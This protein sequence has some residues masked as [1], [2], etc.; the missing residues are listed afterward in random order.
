MVIIMPSV[1]KGLKARRA[2][3]RAKKKIYEEEYRK[4]KA[5]N[6]ALARSRARNQIRKAAQKKAE[7]FNVTGL[8]RKQGRKKKFKQMAKSFKSYSKTAGKSGGG[9]ILDGLEKAFDL[10]GSS[11]FSG[12]RG[13]KTKDQFGP[14]NDYGL[15]G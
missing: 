13:K 3:K 4:A 8:E 2:L 14:D 15:F 5:K 7:K 6:L 11:G 9:D 12:K 10:G 1:L